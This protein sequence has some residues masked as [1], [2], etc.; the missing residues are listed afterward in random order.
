MLAEPESLKM[1]GTLIYPSV[2]CGELSI[3]KAEKMI[4]WKSTSL[5][6][7]INIT[8]GFFMNAGPNFKKE[9]YAAHD[10]LSDIIKQYYGEAK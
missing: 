4:G 1:L 2:Q 9:L 5:D 3:A 6:E 8:S 10:K 7:M